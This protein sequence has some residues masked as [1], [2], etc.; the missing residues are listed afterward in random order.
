MNSPLQLGIV[1][2]QGFGRSYLSVLKNLPDATV[3]ALCDLNEAAAKNLAAEFEV[4]SVFQDYAELLRCHSLDAV[5]IATPHFLH[6]PMTMDALRAGKHVFCEKPLALRA[7]EAREMVTEAKRRGL[8]L[9]CHYNQRQAT[10]VKALKHIVETGM[11]GRAYH[12]DA[13]WMARWTRFMFDAEKTWRVRGDKAGGGILIGRGSH[14]IDAVLYLLGKPRVTAVHASIHNR[15]AR[16]DVEDFA[17]VTLKLEDGC[18]VHIE[19]SYVLHEPQFK[20]S[21]EYHIY[22]DQGGAVYSNIDFNT[23]LK[24]GTCDLTNGNWSDLTPQLDMAGIEREGPTSILADFVAAVATRRSPLVSGDDAAYITELIE[25][26]YASAH[27]RSEIK[28]G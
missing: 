28:L 3:A 23:Q 13:R 11:I 26:G 16:L 27:S 7:S 4:P 19:C 2:I 12:V 21:I 15:L 14:L 20:E 22:G 10:G 24:V 18:I 8:V 9:S 1:G 17:A 6:Y 5:L 25:A